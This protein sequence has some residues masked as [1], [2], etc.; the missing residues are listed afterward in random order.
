LAKLTPK[1]NLK[2]LYPNVAREWH[3][4]KNG[5]LIP[6]DVTPG[7]HKKVWWQCGK[8][9]THVWE[10]SI[11]DRKRGSGCPKCYEIQRGIFITRAALKRSGNLKDKFP[12][13]ANEWHSTKNRNLAP[14]DVTPGSNK[15]VWWQCGKNSTHVWEATISSRTNLSSGCPS[16]NPQISRIQIQIYCELKTIFPDTILEKKPERIDIYIKSHKIAIEYDG[17]YY[18]QKQVIRDKKKNI[19]LNKKGIEVFRIRENDLKKISS[20]DILC[21]HR[22]S[23]LSITK[24][25]FKKLILKYSFLSTQ[26]QKIHDYIKA[27]KLTNVKEYNKCISFLPTCLPELSLAYNYPEI[28]SEWHNKKNFPLT[29]AM[30]PTASNQIFWWQ[31][32]KRKHEWEAGIDSRARG[33]G[34]PECA[35][36]KVGKDNNL[37]FLYP[38]VSKEWHPTKNGDLTPKDVTY[39][40]AKHVWWQC[41][42]NKK[43]NWE[44]SIKLRMKGTSCPFCSG[45]KVGKDNNL[46]ILYPKVAKEW[47]TIKNGDKKPEDFTFGSNKKVWWL[48]PKQHEYHAVIKERT[49]KDSRV[50]GCPYCSG[51]KK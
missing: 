39:G 19:E 35:G 37:K 27:N 20:N 32:S 42:T 51:R 21:K 46:K 43:H 22:D 45:N 38:K 17:F 8:N 29:P 2:V 15:K 4:T 24:R 31:C 44:A 40:S 14:K 10:A 36:K 50:K 7:S 1:Y 11:K 18:H 30:L 9:S 34:C 28:A 48:C 33:R 23:P 6:N 13:I 3:S 12:K 26:K 5:A 41:K 49:R 16:C 25:L 47:H